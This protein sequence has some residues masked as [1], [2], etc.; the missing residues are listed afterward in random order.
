[1]KT[2]A[3]D[4]AIVLDE[5][6]AKYATRV[7]HVIATGER[8]G[9][10]M[11]A[12]QLI[13]IL[14]EEG[15]DQ[16]IAVLRG[17]DGI[18][19]DFGVPTESW[20]AGAWR[21]PGP[22]MSPKTMR[23]MKALVEDWKPDIIQA[24]GGEALKY[25]AL[26]AGRARIVYRRIGSAAPWVATGIRR[27]MH[28]ALMRKAHRVV[29]L[30][31]S[32]RTQTIAMYGLDPRRVVT[33][34]R[35]VDPRR[36]VATKDRATIRAEL[37]IPLDAPVLLSL[38]ALTREKDPLTHLELFRRVVAVRGDAFH[39]IAGDGALRGE[40]EDAIDRDNLAGRAVVL[41][42]RADVADLLEASDLMLLL[43]ATEGM[44]GCLIEAGM[45]GMASVAFD[46]GAVRDVIEDGKSGLI[47]PRGDLDVASAHVLSLLDDPRARE[48]L[49]EGAREHC[50]RR[51]HPSLISERYLAMYADVLRE[52]AVHA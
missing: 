3:P 49:G 29:T 32:I 37:G 17:A 33:I 43:S 18:D 11:F 36:V 35:A 48:L 13:S 38:G 23:R 5:P 47:G 45:A 12:A 19:V 26:H 20:D 2:E 39:L 51:F 30:A 46:V 16:R 50:M 52:G 44:P 7:L 34:P 14:A 8:R 10:E 28:G 41:G 6:A 21:V 24:H 40:L 22:R 1:V 27:S 31:D 25:A 4:R 9:A 42:N 15:F